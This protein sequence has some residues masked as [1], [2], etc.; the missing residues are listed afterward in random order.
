M[1]LGAVGRGLG[2]TAAS[3][4][5]RS[6][7]SRSA[8]AA[9]LGLC[10]WHP[11]RDSN[12][13]R[14]LERSGLGSDRR[15]AVDLTSTPPLLVDHQEAVVSANARPIGLV[16]GTPATLTLAI[17]QAGHGRPGEQSH[18]PARLGDHLA[19]PRERSG[20]LAG[21]WVHIVPKISGR[22]SPAGTGSDQGNASRHGAACHTD[23]T[24]R[25]SGASRGP[26]DGPGSPSRRQDRHAGWHP[27]LMLHV[28]GESQDV[29]LY[30]PIVF[31][32]WGVVWWFMG[33]RRMIRDPRAELR[34]YAEV[35]ARSRLLPSVRRRRRG[36]RVQAAVANAAVVAGCAGGAARSPGLLAPGASRAPDRVQKVLTGPPTAPSND[37]LSGPGTWLTDQPPDAHGLAVRAVSTGTR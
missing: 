2:A 22:N 37:R 7:Q 27:D 18:S 34:R 31:A 20:R 26:S 24:A 10:G 4:L 33:L 21:S 25:P 28:L 16:A 6:R 14:H 19:L 12:P 36:A 32:G 23:V 13:C 30:V 1:T 11:Q 35:R 5:I 9:D 17:H 8:M 29:P 3:R 15:P